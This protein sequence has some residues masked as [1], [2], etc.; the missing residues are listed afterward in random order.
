[1]HL[2][3]FDHHTPEEKLEMWNLQ[4]KA[5]SSLG[6]IMAKYSGDTDG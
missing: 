3:G 1:L 2:L 5:L 4:D 6:I